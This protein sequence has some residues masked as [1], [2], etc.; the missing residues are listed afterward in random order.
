VVRNRKEIP[1]DDESIAIHVTRTAVV[2]ASDGNQK[3]KRLVYVFDHS[4]DIQVGEISDRDQIS[5][6]LHVHN[7]NLKSLHYAAVYSPRGPPITS[8]ELQSLLKGTR[9]RTTAPLPSG[10]LTVDGS[11]FGANVLLDQD[12]ALFQFKDSLPQAHEF[13]ELLGLPKQSTLARSHPVVQIYVVGNVNSFSGGDQSGSSIS[14]NVMI[15]TGPSA[16]EEKEYATAL[17]AWRRD[18][19]MHRRVPESA[20]TRVSSIDEVDQAV[21]NYEAAQQARAE[22]ARTRAADPLY[23]HGYESKGYEH[24]EY[25]PVFHGIP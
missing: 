18:V 7:S 2:D 14:E 20:L 4:A 8:G 6:L 1:V 3:P 12:D 9:R 16:S 11:S 15:V 19:A 21:A 13:R 22:A 24:P 10:V 25:H 5:T 23:R 17:E